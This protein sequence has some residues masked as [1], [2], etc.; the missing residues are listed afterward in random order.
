MITGLNHLTL[1]IADLDH[2]LH[3][4][5]DVLRCRLVARWGRGAYLVAGDLWLC[6]S[7]D[8]EVSA[9]PP[10]RDYTHVAFTV[11]PSEFAKAKTR[12]IDAGAISWKK[13]R[14]EGESFYFLDPDGHKLELHVGDLA[15]RIAACRMAPYEEMEFFD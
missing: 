3:F 5:V 11:E 2:A 12:L 10:R 9:S 6:L 7:L 8:D 4:Y 15:S 1:A 13:S 14:S